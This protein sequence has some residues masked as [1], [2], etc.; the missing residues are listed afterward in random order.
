MIVH[1]L[2]VKVD[3]R[4]EKEWLQWQLDEYIPMV[5]ATHLFTTHN[6]FR[7]L[8]QDDSDGSTYVLQYFTDTMEKFQRYMNEH[9][10]L[11]REKELQKWGNNFVV[12]RTALQTVH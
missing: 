3:S 7:L 9:A 6:F 10:A 8:E 11:L 4:I 12:F 5:M 2:T 1:N